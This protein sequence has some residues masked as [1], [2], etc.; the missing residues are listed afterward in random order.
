MGDLG[1][2]KATQVVECLPSKHEALSSNH[3]TTNLKKKEGMGDLDELQ[4]Q[5]VLI[6]GK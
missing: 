2:G 5:L 6:L 3:N 1:A 4:V